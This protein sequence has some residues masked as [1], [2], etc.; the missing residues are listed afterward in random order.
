MRHLPRKGQAFNAFL[1]KDGRPDRNNPSR[2]A[3]ATNSACVNAVDNAGAA[4]TFFKNVWR[5]EGVD[6]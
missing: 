6:Q 3:L 2:A 4:R 1:K 5:F